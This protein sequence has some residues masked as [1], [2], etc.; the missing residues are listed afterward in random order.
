MSVMIYYT[1]CYPESKASGLDFFLGNTA[2]KI[3]AKFP[4]PGRDSILISQKSCPDEFAESVIL[5][6]G[7]AIAAE[8]QGYTQ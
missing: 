2:K 6:S 5:S 4:K 3:P 7:A 1:N 8:I